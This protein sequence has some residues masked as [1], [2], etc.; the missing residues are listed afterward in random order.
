MQLEIKFKSFIWHT[1]LHCGWWLYNQSGKR[2]YPMYIT[3]LPYMN[4]RTIRVKTIASLY[5]KLPLIRPFLQ[6]LVQAIYNISIKV[7]VTGEFPWQ[8]VSNAES[9]SMPWCH[10]KWWTYIDSISEIP[11]SI[12]WCVPHN[13]NDKRYGNPGGKYLHCPSQFYWRVP[14]NTINKRYGKPR[15][16]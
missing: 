8:W 1:L 11:K 9:N 2:T 15:G 10:H 4:F 5:L 3:S 16:K 12:Y 6:H 7:P 13:T 14:H